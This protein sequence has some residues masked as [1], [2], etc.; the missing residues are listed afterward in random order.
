[1]S[2]CSL[3]PDSGLEDDVPNSHS[4]F[5][6]VPLWPRMIEPPVA[7]CQ[8]PPTWVATSSFSQKQ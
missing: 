3:K 5:V 2:L 6:A 7:K 8:V 1:M 4:G